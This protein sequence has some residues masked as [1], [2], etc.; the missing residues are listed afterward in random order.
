MA[1]KIERLFHQ[2]PHFMNTPAEQKRHLGESLTR[3]EKYLLEAKLAQTRGEYA[4]A[5]QEWAAVQ[6][7]AAGMRCV[8]D[9]LAGRK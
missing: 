5:A 6:G 1:H 8:C 4:R 3:L 7:Y 9:D 2:M